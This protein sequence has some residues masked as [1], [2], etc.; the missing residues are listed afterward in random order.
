VAAPTERPARERAGAQR[1]RLR[2]PRWIARAGLAL[3]LL[4]LTS[5]CGGEPSDLS[6][7]Q[8]ARVVREQQPTLKR[9]YDAAL[10]RAPTREEL[11]LNAEI[12][13]AASGRVTSVQIDE[14]EI[15]MP[16]LHTCLQSAI[17]AW[18]FPQAKD[19]THTS[20]PLIFKPEV[21]PSG[22]TLDDVQEVLRDIRKK[23]A[24]PPAET[25][26]EPQP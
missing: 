2:H 1:A 19:A 15:S 17:E 6:T 12:H 18:K 9:C 7:D 21:V 25:D 5:S 11:R 26:T 13:I 20:L 10:E 23:Q 24:Q 14:G 8:L 3:W 16:G 22:P 4:V